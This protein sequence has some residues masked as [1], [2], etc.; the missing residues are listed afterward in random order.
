MIEGTAV[1][2]QTVV[3]STIVSVT[4]AVVRDSVG[5]FARSSVLA[6]QSTTSG[7]HEVTV[8]TEVVDTVRVVVP[9]PVPLVGKGGTSVTRLATSEE[10]PV[11]RG[12]E[13][14]AEVDSEIA[15]LSSGVTIIPAVPLMNL[16]CRR[17][18]RGCL[19]P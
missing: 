7:R 8:W 10:T 6:G 3:V 15:E 18:Y 12:T 16:W 19:V 11:D 2:G 5:R 4:I 9:L 17:K 1:T 14:V 13:T